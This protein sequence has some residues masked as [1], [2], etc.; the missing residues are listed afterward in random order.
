[1]FKSIIKKWI[2]FFVHDLRESRADWI[3]LPL[4]EKQELKKGQLRYSIS[5]L[6][7]LF[8]HI[9]LLVLV[10]NIGSYPSPLFKDTEN[11]G[12][13]VDFELTEGM[14]SSDVQPL[15]DSES[16]VVIKPSRLLKPTDKQALLLN[17]LVAKLKEGKSPTLSS[18]TLR[19]LVQRSPRLKPVGSNL[20]S[21]LQVQSLKIP[22][23]KVKSNKSAGFWNHIHKSK[24]DPKNINNTNDTEIMEVI[25]RHSFQFRDCYEK[26]LLK[27]EKLSVRAVFL[28]Q[29]SQSKVKKAR[30]ELK[31]NGNAVSR[32][33]LS[34]CLFRQSK[35]LVFN[36][37]KQDLSLR[38]NLIFGL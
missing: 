27:D 35:A 20:M 11:T 26:A 29:L 33:T 7:S 23:R 15:Y 13:E 12:V 3:N 21:N 31:G 32:R 16:Y 9:I 34:H 30:V 1:M 5:L 18:S 4:K 2:L 19:S 22:K 10:W 6:V 24:L 14:V 25:D 8:L 28:L 17:D 37:N 36:K 38:F